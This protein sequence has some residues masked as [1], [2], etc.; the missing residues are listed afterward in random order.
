MSNPEFTD[1]WPLSPMQEGMVFHALYDEG[2]TDVYVVQHVLN[3]IGSLDVAA[4][5]TSWE[6]LLTRHAS[7]RA[8]F[9]QLGS[10][11]LAQVVAG[12]VE[13]PWRMTDASG[14]VEE[15]ALGHAAAV[16]AEER[17]RRFD[18]AVPPLLRFVL[19]RFASDRHRL[20]ITHHHILMDGWSMPVMLRELSA[21]YAASGDGSGLPPVAPYS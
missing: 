19:V 20:V 6:T 12:R 21:T 3:L 18:L 16:S 2:G 5:K 4:L 1:V 11:K 14:L 17:E 9:V 13:L 10:G 8:A 15:E 7:L